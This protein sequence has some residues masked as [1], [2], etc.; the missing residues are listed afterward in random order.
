MKN[1]YEITVAIFDQESFVESLDSKVKIIDQAEAGWNYE[2]LH[3]ETDF[4]REE[5]RDFFDKTFEGEL[6]WVFDDEQVEPEPDNSV[7]L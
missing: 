2:K 3:V 5:L 4:S 7:Q 1:N 6:D